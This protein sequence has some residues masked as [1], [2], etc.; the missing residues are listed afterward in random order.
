LAGVGDRGDV[1]GVEVGVDA[2][3]DS[4]VGMSRWWCPLRAM[5]RV[6][7]DNPAGRADKTLMR[8]C[9]APD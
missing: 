2:D 1:D 6:V 8:N 9:Q 3:D 7:G 5:N 4:G